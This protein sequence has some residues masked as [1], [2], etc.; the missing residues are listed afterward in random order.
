MENQQRTTM[1]LKIIRSK[2]RERKWAK[3]ETLQRTFFRLDV[4][5]V[6][7]RWLRYTT[8]KQQPRDNKLKSVKLV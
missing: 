2:E 5:S 1:V 3:A 8:E 6:R 7:A 4:L